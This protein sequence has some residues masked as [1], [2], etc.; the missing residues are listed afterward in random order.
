M[1]SLTA[2]HKNALSAKRLALAY[3]VTIGLPADLG[4]ELRFTTNAW[5]MKYN[6]FEW[7]GAG[8]LLDIQWPDEDGTLEIHSAQITLSGLD[9]NVISLILNERLDYTPV[10]I[11]CMMMDPDTRAPVGIA[12]WL[13]GTMSNIKII[14]PTSDSGGES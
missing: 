3:M 5:T 9:V 14:P 10:L 7:L 8:A 4:G 13:R 12:Q 2:T 1:R 6:G 11:E